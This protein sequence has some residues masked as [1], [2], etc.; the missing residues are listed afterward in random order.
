[1]R[2]AEGLLDG[3]V[4]VVIGT[5]RL[6]SKDVHFKNLGLLVVDEEAA[7]RRQAQGTPQRTFSERGRSHAFGDAHSAHPVPCADRGARPFHPRN[8]TPRTVTRWKPSFAPTTSASSARPSTGN[9]ARQGQ[10]YFLHNRVED[11]ERVRARVQHLCPK[12]R[13][14][15]GHGQ[16][17]EGQLE[18]VMQRFVN[19]ENDVLVATTIIESGLDIPNANTIIIDRA[20]RF[21]LADLYQLRGRV[22]RGDHKAYAYLMLPRDLLTVGE[23]RK[24]IN[25]I[26]Q[27]STLGAGFKIA[28]RDLEIRGAGNILGL[29]QSGH[30][31]RRRI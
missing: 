8:T 26:K 31:N 1:M 13:V 25:A 2:V 29:A 19:G 14:D 12:A 21:G 6:I 24:R 7:L 23:A 28:L 17:E 18:E 22:G 30:L 5:H 20:D 11:I 4:D 3:S 16:M 10:V 9:Y 15:I 27:Y